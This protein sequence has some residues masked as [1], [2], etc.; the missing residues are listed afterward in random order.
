M[1]RLD[2][3]LLF[4]LKP[5]SRTQTI[6]GQNV[7]VHEDQW[8]TP[9]SGCL[10]GVSVTA[11]F[12]GKYQFSLLDDFS[13]FLVGSVVTGFYVTSCCYDS[14]VHQAEATECLNTYCLVSEGSWSDTVSH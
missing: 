9:D 2:T 8:E 10:S 11:N 12:S 7:T 4:I 1:H 6:F 14:F 5:Y 3:L 13:D